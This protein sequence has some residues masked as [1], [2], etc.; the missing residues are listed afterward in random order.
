ML[1]LVLGYRTSKP[2]TED[3]QVLYCGHSGRA[4]QESI[5]AAGQDIVRFERIEGV[6]ARRG[7]RTRSEEVAVEEAPILSEVE[8]IQKSSKKSK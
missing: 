6:L 4:A 2:L 7:K 3:P 5:D 1:R 8:E